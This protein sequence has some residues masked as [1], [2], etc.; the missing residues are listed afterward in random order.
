MVHGWGATDIV[1]RTATPVSGH[2]PGFTDLDISLDAFWETSI[3][4]FADPPFLKPGNYVRVDIELVAGDALQSWNIIDVLILDCTMDSE[5]RGVVKYSVSG[6]AS[7]VP[8][9]GFYPFTP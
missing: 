4:L 3:E 9:V 5:T 1:G 8:E 2:L 6:K 7:G